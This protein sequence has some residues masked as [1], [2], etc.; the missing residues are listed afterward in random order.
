M[1]SKNVYVA[2]YRGNAIYE[3]APSG[4]VAEIGSF[5]QPTGVAVDAADAVYVFESGTSSVK[6]IVP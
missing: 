4:T 1:F 2:D 5:L 6:K 3:V